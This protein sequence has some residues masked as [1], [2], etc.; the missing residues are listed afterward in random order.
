MTVVR[1]LLTI[2]LTTVLA[3]IAPNAMA[4]DA[5][6][7][8]EGCIARVDGLPPSPL[9]DPED[10]R[11]QGDALVVV[12]ED[13]RRT[14]IFRKGLLARAEAPDGAPGCW[15][16]ALGVNNQGEHPRGPKLRQ[17]DRKTPHGWYRTS[18]K[19]W[20]AYAPAVAIHYP[21]AADAQAGLASGLVTQA[22]TR[23]IEAAVARDDKPSQR[24]RLGGE[25]LFHG[26]GGWA[27]WT[28]G[29]VAFDDDENEEFRSLLPPDMRTD[30]LIL[31]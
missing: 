2:I 13:A 1:L 4:Q 3:A 25:I 28:W 29:C 23:A 14:M 30:V 21:S 11:L 6:P 18:D 7:L 10:P 16:V 27:D 9:F 31:P 17:G 8:P 5:P 22:Q 15:A 20:S 26:G 12:L 19:P 24:T